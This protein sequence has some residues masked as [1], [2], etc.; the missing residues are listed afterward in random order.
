MF[1]TPGN[2]YDILIAS[3]AVGMGLNLDIGRIVFSTVKKFDGVQ[4]RPLNV[5][6]IKQIGG[7]ADT[8]M[9]NYITA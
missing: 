9:P 3:D 8:P 6:E 1:N 7:W 4:Q 2:G 5:S